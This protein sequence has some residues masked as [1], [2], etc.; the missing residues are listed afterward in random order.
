M[1]HHALP[2]LDY[3]QLSTGSIKSRIGGSP[4]GIAPEAAPGPSTGSHVS[5]QTQGPPVNPPSQGVPT[6]PSQPRG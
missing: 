6:N 4:L 1:T 5:P 2:P 3:D